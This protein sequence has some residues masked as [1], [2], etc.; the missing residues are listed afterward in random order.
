MPPQRSAQPNGLWRATFTVI[1]RTTVTI[2]NDGSF[3]GGQ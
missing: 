1:E 2:L 3:L